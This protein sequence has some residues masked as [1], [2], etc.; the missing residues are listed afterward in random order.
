MAAAGAL[1][2]VREA[3]RAVGADDGDAAKV[4]LSTVGE[5]TTEASTDV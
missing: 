5:C 1:A 3:V 2:M 4:A